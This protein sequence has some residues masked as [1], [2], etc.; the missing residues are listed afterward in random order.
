MTP[1]EYMLKIWE[2]IVSALT[3]AVIA[4]AGYFINQSI[5]S[6]ENELATLRRTQDIRKVIY[7]EIGPKLNRIY[8]FIN[9]VGDFGDYEP[10]HIILLKREVDGKFQPYKKLW[11][12]Q[13]VDVYNRFM[14][15]AFDHYAGGIGTPARIRT[16]TSEKK[17]FF[18]R[19]GKEW[20]SEWDASFTESVNKPEMISLYDKLVEAF[21]DDITRDKLI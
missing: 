21:I 16:T 13:T 14:G 1:D 10:S 8:C 5:K 4:I 19:S 18:R 15:S 3:P 17:A 9:D 2:I 20:K 6:R 7:D 12:Q 11:S